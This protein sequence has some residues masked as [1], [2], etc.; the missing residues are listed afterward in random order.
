MS[1]HVKPGRLHRIWVR[2]KYLDQVLADGFR[3]FRLRP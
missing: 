1:D 3:T 2:L